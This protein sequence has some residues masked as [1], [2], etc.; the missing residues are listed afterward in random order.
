[1]SKVVLSRS[2][3]GVT[4]LR[5]SQ[6]GLAANGRTLV[7]SE[8]HLGSQDLIRLAGYASERN[9]VVSSFMLADA[10]LFPLGD[11]EETELSGRMVDILKMYGAEELEAALREEFDGLYVVG[12]NLIASSSGMRVSIRRQ[13]YVET[14]ITGDAEVLL[15]SAWR[16]LHLS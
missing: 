6:G 16:E 3:D 2:R 13:G 14:S 11:A 8:L 15:N 10:Y 5:I 1:M 7:G 9:F 4:D 12:V